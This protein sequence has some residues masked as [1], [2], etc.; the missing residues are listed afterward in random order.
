V[1]RKGFLQKLGLPHH[2]YWLMWALYVITVPAWLWYGLRAK[3]VSFITAINPNIKDGG[4]CGESKIEL[5]KLLPQEYLPKTA[6]VFL[7]TN[8]QIVKQKMV[9]SKIV[10][11]C[12][13]K[14]EFGGRGR[15]VAVIDN[16]IELEKYCNDVGEN[17][18]V[19]E[20]IDFEIELGLFFL[21]MP[22]ENNI[23][24]PS[25]VIKEFM[26][27]IGD[28]KQSV[29]QLMNTTNRSAKQVERLKEM[30]P[31]ILEIVPKE[32]EHILLE[33][34][35][36]HCKGT[37]FRDAN[38][39]VNEELVNIFTNI[40]NQING[41]HY[42]RF[43][44]KVKSIED[45]YNGKNILIMELNGINADPAHIFDPEARLRDAIKM[46][47]YL[48]KCGFEISKNNIKNGVKRIPTKTVIARVKKFLYS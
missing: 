16:D 36:N 2:E 32:K 3:N 7:P 11:P 15:K 22:N 33:P 41:V 17:F 38:D 9:D 46:H 12:I 18:M 19:Q 42:G 39:L 30:N 5:N 25:V 26:T 20:K 28:G 14:P 31:A 23:R 21:K 8:L 27:V 6:N 40:C 34:I 48:A 44:M 47:F 35:G 24:I 1:A 29:L 13:A 4:F 37:I 45:L 43:D 10:Y